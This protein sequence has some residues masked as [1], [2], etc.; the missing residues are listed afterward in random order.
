MT[1]AEAEAEFTVFMVS[2]GDMSYVGITSRVVDD[3]FQEWVLEDARSA[4]PRSSHGVALREVPDEPLKFRVLDKTTL[5]EANKLQKILVEKQ[6]LTPGKHGYNVWIGYSELDDL[7]PS[8]S[9]NPLMLCG[10]RSDQ[11][12]VQFHEAAAR[13]HAEFV[14]ALGD[15]SLTQAIPGAFGYFLR[16][17][18]RFSECVAYDPRK[19]NG[20]VR[21]YD[22]PNRFRSVNKS[23][24]A[25]EAIQWIGALVLSIARKLIVDPDVSPAHREVLEAYVLDASGQ[26]DHGSRLSIISRTVDERLFY[27]LQCRPSCSAYGILLRGYAVIKREVMNLVEADPLAPRK[28][29]QLEDVERFQ[30]GETVQEKLVRQKRRRETLQ[31]EALRQRKKSGSASNLPFMDAHPVS[32]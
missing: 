16:H 18:T 14:D 11:G 9:D 17:R 4:A 1:A 3:V 27:S 10:W 19:Y 8:P 28:L 32:K 25:I 26:T 31:K 13:N 24:F 29:H 15:G 7:R 12:V 2:N 22:A 23:E 21:V 6:Q 20:K 5:Y 30:A